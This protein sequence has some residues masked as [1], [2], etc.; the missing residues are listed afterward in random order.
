MSAA[1][2]NLLDIHKDM[3]EIRTGLKRIRQELTEHFADMDP[4]EKYGRQMWSFVGKATSQIE[5]LTDDINLADSTFTEVIK[6]FGEEDKNMSSSEFYGI[7]KTF[8]TSY[9]VQVHVV[10]S[11]H[12]PPDTLLQ[13]C[14]SDNQTAAEEQLAIQ[15]R[16]QAMEES[17][18]TRQKA[19][20]EAVANGTAG[21]EDEDTSVLD[22]L[23]EKLR[24]GD[25]V[26]RRARRARPS[27][28]N[29]PAIPATLSTDGNP[30]SAANDTADIARDML[31]RLQSDGFQ[32]FTANSTPTPRR[33]TRR[34]RTGNN[35]SVSGVS[36]AELGSPD[37]GSDPLPELPVDPRSKAPESEQET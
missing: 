21:T 33:Q 28:E 34:R 16:K 19:Q 15:K 26:G 17:K 7:F 5:D 8:V 13:K 32:A 4:S 2:V 30:A 35:M 10:D 23:L 14:K 22:N 24:N 25:T 37:V 31:A 9:K 20:E 3:G 1:S 12:N 36:D 18:I 6:Y 27:A 11:R 29:R